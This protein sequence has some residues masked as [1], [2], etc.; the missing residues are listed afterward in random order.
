MRRLAVHYPD[1]VIAGV[2]NR[3][4]R[5]TAY[6]HRFDVGRVGNLR[7]HWKIPCCEPKAEHARGELLTIKKAAILL[8][9]APFHDPSPA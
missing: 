6:G 4:G 3:Q 7:R 5:T 9:V 1:A 8:G 2:L